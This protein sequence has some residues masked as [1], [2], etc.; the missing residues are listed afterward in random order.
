MLGGFPYQRVPL[1]PADWTAAAEYYTNAVS[2]A[3]NF[4]FA[5]GNRALALYQLRQ[6]D[7]AFRE[8]R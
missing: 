8:L 3:P 7:N 6:D 2:L 1:L 5:A 4:A